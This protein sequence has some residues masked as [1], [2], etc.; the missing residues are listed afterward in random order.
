MKGRKICGVI[1][2]FVMLLTV[3]MYLPMEALA[4]TN[5]QLVF[6]YLTGTLGYKK[7]AACAIMANIDKESGFNPAADAGSAGGYGLCQWS[8]TART[9]M[10]AWCQAWC[11]TN[12]FDANSTEG[13]IC[14]QLRFLDHELK[15]KTDTKYKNTLQKITEIP[16]TADGAENAAA[17]WCMYYEVPAY[18][19]TPHGQYD[20][21]GNPAENG[22]YDVY[23]QFGI[24][25]CPEDKIGKT[26]SEYRGYIAKTVYWPRYSGSSVQIAAA[27]DL[28][29][30]PYPRPTEVIKRGMSGDGVKWVQHCLFVQLGYDGGGYGANGDGV[31][32]SFGGTTETAVRKF[33]TEHNLTV[34]GAVG[35]QTRTELIKAVEKVLAAAAKDDMPIAPYKRPTADVKRGMSGDD[36]RW[37]QYCLYKQ[38]KFDGGTYGVDG[39]FGPATEATV[40]QFQKA[41]ALTENGIV[42]E[43]TRNA[44]VEAV[45]AAIA[46]SSTTTTAPVT[47]APVT[48]APVTGKDL[49]IAPYV[50]PTA[51]V[52][53]GMNG[54]SVMWLQYCLFVQ[55]KYDGGGYGAGGDGVDGSFGPAT[56]ASVRAFQLDHNL[57]ANGVLNTETRNALV[58]AVQDK[59]NA[60]TTTTTTQPVTTTAQPTTTSAKTTTTSA[61][62]AATTAK[63]TTAQNMT[64]AAKATAT[65]AAATTVRVTTTTAVLTTTVTTTTTQGPADHPAFEKG[66]DVSAEQEQIDWKAAAEGGVRFA[67]IRSA[68]T[69]KE[70]PEYAADVKF[71]KNYAAA[72]AA[73]VYVGTYFYT[74]ADSEA[75]MQANIDALLKT[76][77]GKQFDLPVYL[78]FG[79]SYRQ[80]DLGKEKLTALAKYGCSLLR[81]AGYQPGV[82]ASLNWFANYLDAD[83]LRADGNEI[84]LEARP[85]PDRA[86][87][88]DYYN[89]ADRCTVWQYSDCGEV[90]GISGPVHVDVCY[91]IFAATEPSGIRRGDANKDSSVDLKDVVVMRRFLA[92]GWPDQADKQNADVTRDGMFDLKDVVVLRRYL[93]GGSGLTLG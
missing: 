23:T 9:E 88:P 8:G 32:G 91:S 78:S 50:R 48:T 11:Q 24:V 62:A 83:A 54:E 16:D 92:G 10:L 69:G 72:K 71:E 93:A 74:C 46:L 41:H 2:A 86:A 63:A 40:K 5:E 84:W 38:L 82:Y 89:Y 22:G 70:D 87:D 30:A 66:I 34:D 47:T 27:N 65:T 68:A 61:K 73:G 21:D 26:E 75:E 13:Q 36:V 1:T 77:S 39:S 51:D 17:Y 12:G 14:S 31:D 4:A 57:N 3:A 81:K 56:E 18:R 19:S 6:S 90:P 29:I 76:L 25:K 59:L 60:K 43:Q 80:K 45:K 55:L 20:K 64:T 53:R 44:L 42:N 67:V 15:D 85:L 58:K 33:Q 35:Q 49:P 79:Q 52:S 37:V 7:A 28:P